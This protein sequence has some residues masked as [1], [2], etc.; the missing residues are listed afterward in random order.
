MKDIQQ[1]IK[2]NSQEGRYE[3]IFPK[4]FIDAVEDRES[5][6]NL[7]EILSGFNM[8]FLS[9]NGSRELTRLQV[10][11]SI[12]KTGLWIT[13]VLYDKTVVTEWYAGEAVDDNSWKNLSNWRVGSNMVV[14]DTGNSETAVMSQKAVT[15]SLSSNYKNFRGTTDSRPTL[16]EDDSGFPFYDTT[17]KKYICWDG[18]VWT[19]F[20]GSALT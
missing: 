9:Y 7:T 18:N 5:G 19:N 2:K 6:N 10:P 14:Q 13:Y 15:N 16:T 4:T 12:R 11:M 8:Y 20:D 3:D 1:L 17:L